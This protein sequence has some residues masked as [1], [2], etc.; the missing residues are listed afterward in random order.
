MLSE[1]EHIN[2]ILIQHYRRLQKLEEQKARFGIN[3]R[4]EILIEIEDVEIEIQKI[5]ATWADVLKK[6]NEN[7]KIH[8]S[9]LI[10][11]EDLLRQ[12]IEILRKQLEELKRENSKLKDGKGFK[13]F[14]V[15]NYLR[16]QDGDLDKEIVKINLSL[17]K[18]FR[19][20][21]T[22]RITSK[23]KAPSLSELDEMSLDELLDIQQHFYPLPKGYELEALMIRL[24]L[25][26]SIN[27]SVNAP[28]WE[29]SKVL[30]TIESVER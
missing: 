9:E 4:P 7:L 20:F 17:Q 23:K 18:R 22:N 14:S 2:N 5:K 6:D 16:E 11:N 24:A 28:E 27:L 1:H 15:Y 13:N 10:K 19:D 21:L 30:K 29:K 26:E 25:D 8:I 3:T 12:E